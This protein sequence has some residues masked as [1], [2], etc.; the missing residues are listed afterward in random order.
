MPSPVLNTEY[1]KRRTYCLNAG[2]TF[3]G[4]KEPNLTVCISSSKRKVHEAP[5][6][7]PARVKP[8]Q[9]GHQKVREDF[10]RR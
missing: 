7:H 10:W 2:K 9:R 5:G 6:R 4:L 8:K 1:I 3:S